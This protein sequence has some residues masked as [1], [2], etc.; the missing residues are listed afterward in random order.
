MTTTKFVSST[1]MSK[2]RFEYQTTPWQNKYTSFVVCCGYNI[3]HF[4]E[5]N[6]IAYTEYSTS[7]YVQEATGSGDVV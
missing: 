4:P 3:L 2:N 6:F 7:G 5:H 1:L